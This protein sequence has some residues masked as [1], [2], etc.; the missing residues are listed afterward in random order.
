[1]PL[2]VAESSNVTVRVELRRDV[3]EEEMLD[4]D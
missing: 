2:I 4:S 3:S 1:M